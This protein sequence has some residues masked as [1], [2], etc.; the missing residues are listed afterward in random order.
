MRYEDD[1]T[2]TSGTGRSD[3]GAGRVSAPLP[4]PLR[5]F[6][7]NPRPGTLPHGDVHRTPQQELRH[8]RPGCPQHFRTVPAGAA[9]GHELGRRRPQPTARQDHAGLAQRRRCCPHLRRHRFRQAGQALRRRAA[10][11]L[12]HAG[13][14]RQLPGHRQL[15]LRR[16]DHCL[17]RLHSAVS[18]QGVGLRPCAPQQGQGAQGDHLSDQ[19]R[20]RPGPARQGRRDGGCLTPAWLPTP[21]TATTPTS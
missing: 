6:R 9:H 1:K 21:T 5:P 13:Q 3:A 18:A 10:A 11:I 12:R 14:G 2:S 19:A 7:G 4:R 20:H 17:A 16:E 8:H 15:P